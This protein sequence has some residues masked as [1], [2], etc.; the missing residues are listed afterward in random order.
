[1]VMPC[2]TIERSIFGQ[3]PMIRSDS[4][5][6]I[7]Q[8]QI[9]PASFDF[10]LGTIGYRMRSSALPQGEKVSDLIAK[11]KKY[12]FP[13]DTE[14][15]HYLE[16]GGGN[17]KMTYVIP[18]LESLALPNDTWAEFTAKSSTGRCDVFGR[19]L[20]DHVGGYDQVPKGYH[21]PLYL[22]V[23]PLSHDV[24][25][26]TGL[27][28]VQGR[29]KTDMSE[30]ITGRMVQEMHMHRSIL[31]SS[32]GEPLDINQLDIVD[33]E[34]YFHVDLTRDVVGFVAK[35]STL[36][37]DLTLDPKVHKEEQLLDPYIFWEPI[38][39]P[40]SGM[41][42]LLPDKFYL[43][44][45]KERVRIPAEVCGQVQ[46][47]K[48]GS[49]EMRPHYAGFFD[50]GFGGEQGTNGV[51]EVRAR[52]VTM[53]VVDGQRICSMRF[54][55]TFGVPSRLYGQGSSYT[56]AGPSISKHFKCR[57]DVW[58]MGYWSQWDT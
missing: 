54:E 11:Y 2:Q 14:R 24:L 12:D 29:F 19:V 58:H 28:L 42:E 21:G 3:V 45:T 31:H 9:Q 4:K 8:E 7:T 52:E 5:F 20:A 38:R 13:L 56:G 1:M 57:Y 49:G 26:R 50:N 36:P 23:T 44:A 35:D 40:K 22:E 25:V 18:L 6:K 10:R 53:R 55:R 51:L 16:A 17:K 33:D 30:H 47:Y 37:I 39:R 27:P 32:G 48:V 41:L 34:L 43:L 15:T 46:P